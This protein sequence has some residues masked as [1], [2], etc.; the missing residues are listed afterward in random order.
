MLYY[1]LF[2]ALAQLG[3][4]HTGSVEVRGSNPLCSTKKEQHPLG[5]LLFFHLEI[6]GGFEPERVPAL[7]KQFGEFPENEVDL[8][9]DFCY[10]KSIYIMF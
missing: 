6:L 8:Q 4:R 1:F 7:R 2:G 3:A 5:C 10:C 9:Q